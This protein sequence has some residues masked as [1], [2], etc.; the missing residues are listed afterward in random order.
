MS[1]IAQALK[2]ILTHGQSWKISQSR[3]NSNKYEVIYFRS[4]PLFLV[5]VTRVSPYIVNFS[6]T[7]YSTQPTFSLYFTEPII[8]FLL[9]CKV[10]K[11]SPFVS[12]SSPLESQSAAT[13]VGDAA[14]GGDESVIY[15]GQRPLAAP[16]D[17]LYD[18]YRALEP[19]AGRTEVILWLVHVY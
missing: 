4:I 1:V 15:R 13:G 2:I 19:E 17:L 10:Y 18:E 6:C 16:L 5:G 11:V 8:S 14:A 9:I 3:K 12:L 7:R